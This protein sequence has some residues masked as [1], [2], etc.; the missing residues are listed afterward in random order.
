[1]FTD[2]TDWLSKTVDFDW[3]AGRSI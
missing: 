3:L 2:E 1:V